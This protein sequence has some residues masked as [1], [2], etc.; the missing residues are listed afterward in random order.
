MDGRGEHP[1]LWEHIE[2]IP[3]I[4]VYLKETMGTTQTVHASFGFST[5][6][7]KGA[8]AGSTGED[9]LWVY[10]HEHRLCVCRWLSL[11]GGGKWR[12]LSWVGVWNGR[13]NYIYLNWNLAMA[14]RGK[15]YNTM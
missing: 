12:H 13:E 9:G 11:S 10:P 4:S 6:R 1:G 8:D 5:L 3:S 2:I 15:P 7:N 14:S